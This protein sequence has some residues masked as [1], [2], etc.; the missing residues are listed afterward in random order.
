MQYNQHYE[1]YKVQTKA[2]L[3]RSLLGIKLLTTMVA[4]MRPTCEVRHF[5]EAASSHDQTF[6]LSN[7]RE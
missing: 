1:Y 4:S 5:Q 2:I 6:T 7:L 3:G